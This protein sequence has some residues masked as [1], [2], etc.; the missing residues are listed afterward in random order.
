MGKKVQHKV[1]KGTKAE[2]VKL[3]NQWMKENNHKSKVVSL[4]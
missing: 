2:Y 1:F 3:A 4:S